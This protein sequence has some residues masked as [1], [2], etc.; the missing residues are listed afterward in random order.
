MISLRQLYLSHVAQTSEMPMLLEI[1]RAEGVNL[2]DTNGK[3]YYDMNSGIAVSSLGHG[4]PVVVKAIK[5]QVD[6][7]MHTMVYGEHVQ[8][9][10]VRFATLLTEHL[11]ENLNSVYFL[12]AGTEASEL[13]MKIAKKYTGRYKLAAC[14]NAYHGST[15][16]AESLRSDL[17]YK[18][19][20][21]PLVPGIHHIEFNNTDS[22]EVLDSS[23]SG[24]LIE[25]VQGEAGVI[26]PNQEWLEALVNKCQKHQI[27]LIAD[28]IQSGFGRTGS[29]FAHQK[30]GIIP[31]ILL[32]GKAMG[33][34]MPIAGVVSSQDIMGCLTKN[35][36]LG[37]ISTFGGH[38]V[39]S[40]AAYASLKV[41]LDDNIISSIKAKADY[42]QKTLSKHPIIKE[43]R[44]AGLMMA[45][46][47]TNRKY[48]KHIVAQALHLGVVVD[49][50]L[51][52]NR[53]FRVAPPLV[54]TMEELQEACSILLQAFDYARD[55]YKKQSTIN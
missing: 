15:Q 53:S 48:L 54:I 52:N 16:G 27:L 12:N 21:L 40:A 45:V 6:K 4:H 3:K 50:F 38:P 34:G 17:E 51:F 33:G 32:I 43:V 47:P 10:Q 1:E 49:W 7:Y 24:V 25:I 29:L 14:R 11:S 36:A 22:L 46:E 26:T 18:G 41:L 42:I 30:Y 23:F 31:D 35:P 28:E 44:N 8:T 37:H 13:A 19:A 2:Y 5:D 9:P 55:Y 20:Y 39:C